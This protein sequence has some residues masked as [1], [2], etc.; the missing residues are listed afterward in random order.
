MHVSG[1]HENLDPFAM[2]QEKQ[3]SRGFPT[4]RLLSS[5]GYDSSE[6]P[7]EVD[8]AFQYRLPKIE[9]YHG[10]EVVIGQRCLELWSPNSRQ[11]AYYP[12]RRTIAKLELPAMVTRRQ[13]NG[14]LGVFDPTFAPQQYDSARPWLGCI[15]WNLDQPEWEDLCVHWETEV[16]SALYGKLSPE[17]LRRLISANQV[18]NYEIQGFEDSLYNRPS[19]WHSRPLLPY[20]VDFD[21]LA[22][23]RTYEVVIDSGAA[24]QRGMREKRAWLEFAKR[25]TKSATCLDIMRRCP[26]LEARDKFIGV[27]INGA[28]E[29][30]VLFFLTE[31]GVPCFIVHELIEKE[32]LGELVVPNTM[33]GTRLEKSFERCEYDRVALVASKGSYTRS[34]TP[35][36]YP[37][38]P[39]PT[40]TPPDCQ[41]SGSRWQLNLKASDY[42]PRHR[43]LP[44][45]IMQPDCIQEVEIMPGFNPWLRPPPI[46]D[47]ETNSKWQTFY[48]RPRGE[49]GDS[50]MVREEV[51][52]QRELQSNETMWYDRKR[53]R[54]LVLVTPIEAPDGYEAPPEFG[55]PAPRL[56]Y[57]RKVGNDQIAVEAPLAWIYESQWPIP[58]DAGKEK[59]RLTTQ[60]WVDQALNQ[61]SLGNSP[62]PAKVDETDLSDFSDGMDVDQAPLAAEAP[63]SGI[64]HA[65]PATGTVVP[66]VSELS[67]P[68]QQPTPS[69]PGARSSTGAAPPAFPPVRPR[70]PPTPTFEHLQNL[71]LTPFLLFP[72]MP[73]SYEATR[74]VAL[75]DALVKQ[76]E[77]CAWTAAHRY[78]HAPWV[79]HL[80]RMRC[81]EDAV[82]LRGLVG[83]ENVEIRECRF[84]TEE[85]YNERLLRPSTVKIG[86]R[87]T[88][89]A[90]APVAQHAIPSGL[91]SATPY[92][93]PNVPTQLDDSYRDAPPYQRDPGFW[94]SGRADAHKPAYPARDCHTH[95]S[96]SRSPSRGDSRG[97]RRRASSPPSHRRSSQMQ[98]GS[99]K[100][101]PKLPQ[102]MTGP[103]SAGD[104]PSNPPGSSASSSAPVPSATAPTV[105][106]P[107]ARPSTNL[108]QCAGVG[109]GERLSE[110]KTKKKKRPY[111]PDKAT[112]AYVRR[113]MGGG[114]GAAPV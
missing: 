79:D 8:D 84:L 87:L 103:S 32:P 27:W 43:F 17:Y 18:L 53:L 28:P 72:E 22:R 105:P 21:T 46:R 90:L 98:V 20:Q 76:M 114:P 48:E 39:Q 74:F 6:H 69:A 15:E 65:M 82:M 107:E 108:L 10:R 57:G 55:Y 24:V 35:D 93:P 4:L 110:G 51:Y 112:R 16:D 80:V 77:G 26:T 37:G 62:E 71:V 54:C 45:P 49:S 30:D 88:T 1:V 109:L 36:P 85:S 34:V 11:E 100:E 25:W 86:E 50:V 89:E 33:S 42:P 56:S 12:G 97:K 75:L 7:P 38:P 9:R 29:Q 91:S 106:D 58:G 111:R 3:D 63:A 19:L 5:Y 104:N 31:M 47:A 68:T 44:S 61:V 70:P 2:D 66:L 95:S 99:E 52:P 101:Q 40:R 102:R 94:G 23:A 14:S 83:S 81:K 59:A 73:G 92:C 113:R 96:R 64:A 78:D 60:A 41:R 13:H 67:A